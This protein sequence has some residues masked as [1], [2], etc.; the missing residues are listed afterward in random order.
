M[1]T[2]LEAAKEHAWREVAAIEDAYS[3]GDLDEACWYAAMTELVVPAYLAAETAE[4]GSGHS[5][6]PSDWDYSRGVI[7]EAIPRAGTFLDVG[8]ANG[9]LMESIHRWTGVQPYGLEIS[10]K[11]ADLARR[12]LPRWAGRIFVGNAIEW[13]PSRRFD[14]VRTNLEYVPKPR[15]PE[16]IAH[17]LDR[18]VSPGGRL[19]IG[20]FNEESAHR[21]VER[22]V[23]AWGFRVAGRAERPHRLDPRLAYRIFWIDA[24]QVS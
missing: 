20:K 17:L 5:G 13:S 11:L 24:A 7:A 12:R 18:V 16:L 9:L 3:R 4:G 15:R 19:V 23:S 10:P 1:E 22:N 6:S 21:A 8:C 2:G 14:I